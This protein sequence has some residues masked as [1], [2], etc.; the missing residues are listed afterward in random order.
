MGIV[1]NKKELCNNLKAAENE[2]NT[3]AVKNKAFFH[4]VSSASG[5]GINEL[6]ER[7]VKSL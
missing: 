1:G 4:L 2:V 6:F 5:E 3:I 7:I